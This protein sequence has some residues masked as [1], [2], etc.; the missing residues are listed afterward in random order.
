MLAL[1][2]DASNCRRAGLKHLLKVNFNFNFK[3]K[4]NGQVNGKPPI[5]PG[6]PEPAEPP[7]F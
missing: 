7:G 2:S 6:R 4:V 5:G 1:E 3:V